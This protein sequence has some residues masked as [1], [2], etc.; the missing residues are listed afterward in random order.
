MP[1]E[2]WQALMG[3]SLIHRRSQLGCEVAKVA[4]YGAFI[5]KFRPYK[6]CSLVVSTLRFG[7]GCEAGR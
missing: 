7:M 4:L 3:R 2:D 1:S 5:A 6:L